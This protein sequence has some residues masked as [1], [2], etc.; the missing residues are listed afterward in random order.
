MSAG[1][2]ALLSRSELALWVVTRRSTSASRLGRA[3][4]EHRTVWFSDLGV[5]YKVGLFDFALARRPD[6]L[7][8]V[9][10]SA[11]ASGPTNRSAAYLRLLLFLEGATIGVFIAQD[12]LLFYVFCEAMLIP[13]YVLIGGGAG[14]D[15]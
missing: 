12:L 5:S 6:R 4:G 14:P 13:L 7:V 9:A 2:F 15:D 11:T 3:S 8:S 1:G 10:A